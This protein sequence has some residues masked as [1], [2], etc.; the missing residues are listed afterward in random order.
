MQTALN[1]TQSQRPR[2]AAAS[3]FARLKSEND[4]KAA[5]QMSNIH[6]LLV[7]KQ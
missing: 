7:K 2:L 3:F 5:S 1:L 4:M 6:M